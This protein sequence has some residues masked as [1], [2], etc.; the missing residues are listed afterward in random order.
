MKQLLKITH[1][2]QGRVRTSTYVCLMPKSLILFASFYN[3]PKWLTY[4]ISFHQKK[5]YFSIKALDQK[6]RYFMVIQGLPY[7]S[8][9]FSNCV[10]FRAPITT[11]LCF[12]FLLLSIR[13]IELNM[14]CITIGLCISFWFILFIPSNTIPSPIPFPLIWISLPFVIFPSNLSCRWLHTVSTNSFFVPY[15]DILGFLFVCFILST[16]FI[17]A[18]KIFFCSITF[19]LVDRVIIDQVLWHQILNTRPLMLLNS[20]REKLEDKYKWALEQELFILLSRLK[21]M[22]M[23]MLSVKK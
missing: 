7:H 19:N 6:I 4:R 16:W 11:P 9:K 23:I 2:I 1:L 21:G 18:W 12:I 8:H 15:K 3:S 20:G 10:S 5:G 17:F 22:V 14:A 13:C